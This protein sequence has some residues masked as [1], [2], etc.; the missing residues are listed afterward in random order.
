MRLRI[1]MWQY[2]QGHTASVRRAFLDGSNDL[3]YRV[4]GGGEY[5]TSQEALGQLE[6]AIFEHFVPVLG[7]GSQNSEAAPIPGAELIASELRLCVEGPASCGL[8]SSSK[9]QFICFE[10]VLPFADVQK[11]WPAPVVP[12][13]KKVSSRILD[14]LEASEGRLKKEVALGLV[15]TIDGFTSRRFEDAWRLFPQDRK[16]KRGERGP[17]RD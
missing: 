14:A 7:Y 6:L 3:D 8:W 11:L 16:F 4:I 1:A 10:P 2:R 17:G 9:N 12:A 5:G 13:K 15:R